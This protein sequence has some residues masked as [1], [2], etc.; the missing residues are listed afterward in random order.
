MFMEEIAEISDALFYY[1][2]LFMGGRGSMC[3]GIHMWVR[4]RIVGVSPPSIMWVELDSGCQAWQQAHLFV[5]PFCLSQ[6]LIFKS[7]R[8]SSRWRCSDTVDRHDGRFQ[9]ILVLL[10]S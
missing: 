5:G 1:N 7:R 4:G 9:P 6:F 8:L 3:H 2:Y 10:R